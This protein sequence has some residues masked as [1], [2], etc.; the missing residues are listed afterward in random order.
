M[1]ISFYVD[2]IWY[3]QLHK[4]IVQ[5]I[6]LCLNK[7][8][9]YFWFKI[10]LGCLFPFLPLHMITVGLSLHDAQIISVIAPLVAIIGP[11]IVCPLADRL[12]G[13]QGRSLRIILA[14][15]ALLGALCY[16]FLLAI[17]TVKRLD[18]R[19]PAIAFTCNADGASILYEHC[20]AKCPDLEDDQVMMI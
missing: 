12:G 2:F 4:Y 9:I 7:M 11:L 8:H 13:P 10:G 14:I 15:V 18:A 5:I 6:F 19:P 16:V 17:P 1:S 3:V 20:G